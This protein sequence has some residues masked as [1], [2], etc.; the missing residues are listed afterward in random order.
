MNKAPL[1]LSAAGLL[2]MR[3]VLGFSAKWVAFSEMVCEFSA[4]Y[5]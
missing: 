1:R 5:L 2:V 4:F 3:G